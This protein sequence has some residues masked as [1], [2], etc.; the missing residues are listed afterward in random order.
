MVARC[1]RAGRVKRQRPF[2]RWPKCPLLLLE[3]PSAPQPT[4]HNEY[5]VGIRTGSDPRV[6][7]T[8]CGPARNT[9]SFGPKTLWDMRGFTPRRALRTLVT[10]KLRPSWISVDYETIANNFR[11]LQACT[12]PAVTVVPTVSV[13]AG[14]CP[15]HGAQATTVVLLVAAYAI[16]LSLRVVLHVLLTAPVGR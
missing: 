9:V 2:Q 5:Y 10:S 3:V 7:T 4:Q 12:G 1:T 6:H 13:L 8:H 16:K 14:P 11:A 15:A